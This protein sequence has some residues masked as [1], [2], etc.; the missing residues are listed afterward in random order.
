MLD[1]RQVTNS[2][3]STE[4]RIVINTTIVLGDIRRQVEL[5]LTNRDMMKFQ[6]LLG[7]TAL[8]R[9]FSI[10]PGHSNLLDE[11]AL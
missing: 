7:R 1:E 10:D 3:G 5:T 9:R 2:G 11:P 4:S 8:R 6:M